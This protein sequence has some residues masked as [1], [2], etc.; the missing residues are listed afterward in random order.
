MTK[1]NNSTILKIA[2][3]LV[4][5]AFTA[6]GFYLMTDFRLNAVETAAAKMQDDTKERI[7][8][9][10]I[11][12]DAVDDDINVLKSVVGIIE[13]KLTELNET[14]KKVLEELKK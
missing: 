10:R 13:Y 6:Y 11:E 3:P 5:V 8:Q 7:K 9:S 14:M 12:D 1:M 2:I 4:C